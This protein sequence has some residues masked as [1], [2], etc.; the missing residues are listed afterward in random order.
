MKKSHLLTLFVAVLA[1]V[2]G[3][4][5]AQAAKVDVCH[6]P[7]GNPDNWHTISVSENALQAHLSHGDLEGSCL[8]NCET[9]CDDGD[10]CTQDVESDPD[11]CICLAV[12][13]PVNCDDSNPCTADSCDSNLGACVYDTSLPNGDAC[14]DGNYVTTF[15][16]CTDGVCQGV[17]CPCTDNPGFP[18]WNA[19][20]A[21]PGAIPGGIC[22]VDAGQC[23]TC[24]DPNDVLAF[25]NSTISVAASV[26]N[27]FPLPGFPFCSEGTALLVSPEEA[28]SCKAQLQAALDA[29]GV[30]CD[31]GS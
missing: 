24:G 22:K 29:A 2:F 12:P 26:N 10:A 30:I 11:Q 15:D 28:A 20:L 3:A 1:I 16:V 19:V 7:P 5:S 23:S 18:L 25:S 17:P 9:L 6:L 27:T 21:D 8:A 13:E 4:A 31:D 14:D